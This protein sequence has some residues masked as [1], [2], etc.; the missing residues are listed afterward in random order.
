M[1]NN[2]ERS[3][4]EIRSEIGVSQNNRYKKYF[5]GIFSNFCDL[6]QISTVIIISNIL[7]QKSIPIFKN[8]FTAN[9]HFSRWLILGI[10]MFIFF[11]TERKKKEVEELKRRNKIYEDNKHKLGKYFL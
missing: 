3:E 11:V 6:S 1:P 10:E 7:Y 4:A 5:M 9:L 8:D 2:P